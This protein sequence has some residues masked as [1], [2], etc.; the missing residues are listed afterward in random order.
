MSMQTEPLRPDIELPPPPPPRHDLAPRRRRA[1][2]LAVIAAIVAAFLLLAVA[3]GS[4]IPA[5][6]TSDGSASVGS[7]GTSPQSPS[8]THVDGG[9]DVRA[10]ADRVAPAVV[11]IDTTLASFSSGIAGRAAGTGMI[12]TSGGEVLTNNHVI[13][14]AS[15]IRVSVAGTGTYPARVLGAD[16]TGDVALLQLRG[17]SGLPTATLADSSNLTIG[18]EVVAMGNALGRGGAP[19]VAAGT[20]TGLDRSI[21]ARSDAGPGEHL[22]GLIQTDA[23]ISPGESGGPL[24]NTAGQVI[25]M[26]TAGAPTQTSTAT[27]V[28]FAIPT[29]DAVS[30]VDRI[31][32]GRGGA[33]VVL[34]QA[35][36]LG[37]EAAPLTP[38]TAARTGIDARSG[39][40]VAG[41]LPNGPAAQAG[42]RPPSV[43]TAIDGRAVGSPTALGTMLHSHKPG[44]QVR[45]TWVDTSGTHTATVSLIAGPAV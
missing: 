39:V 35:G 15:T 2:L 20:I 27:R 41:I 28:G 17:A 18:E 13:Q 44:E 36:F 16:P 43:I 21:V 1:R 14:N 32:S 31:E 12:V 24:V 34:G 9:A 7:V 10:I 19:S 29:N 33:S 26:I 5:S 3:V 8:A 38:E 23:S 40:V 22:H 45:V 4:M 11:N 37:I 6:T 42:I 25:G 30:V